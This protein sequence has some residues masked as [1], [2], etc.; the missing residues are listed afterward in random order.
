MEWFAFGLKTIQFQPVPPGQEQLPL[1]QVALC[2]VS[3]TAATVQLSFM[4]QNNCNNCF[5]I[6]PVAL[7]VSPQDLAAGNLFQSPRL[8]FFPAW[9]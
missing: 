6:F 1:E 9:V 4:V 8:P 3:I 5:K 7:P 2:P